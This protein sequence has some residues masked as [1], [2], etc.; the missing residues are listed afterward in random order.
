MKSPPNFTTAILS[1]A[2]TR[3]SE[4]TVTMPS[5][6]I[7]LPVMPTESLPR[8]K[9]GIQHVFAVSSN[10]TPKSPRIVALGPGFWTR[11]IACNRSVSV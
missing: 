2:D 11:I 8:V 5:S 10:K 3:Q 6:S 7:P 9:A 1:G 4:A